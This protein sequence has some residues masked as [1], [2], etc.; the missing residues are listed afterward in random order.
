[1]FDTEK[2]RQLPIVFAIM[3]HEIRALASLQRSNLVAASQ[4]IRGIYCRNGHARQGVIFI[5]V[6][7]SERIIGIEGVGEERD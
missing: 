4:R 2:V 6:Q 5:C 7:A 3:D 1:V